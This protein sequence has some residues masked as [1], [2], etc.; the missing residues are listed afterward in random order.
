ML[1][2]AT[3]ALT[4]YCTGEWNLP[5]KCLSHFSS[6][7]YS[8]RQIFKNGKMKTDKRMSRVLAIVKD[9]DD[10]EWVAIY[11]AAF[12]VAKDQDSKARKKG[13]PAVVD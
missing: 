11:T 4:H 1:P 8:D 2:Q 12:E 10:D 9:L 13:V 7:N 3:H 6:D 5:P